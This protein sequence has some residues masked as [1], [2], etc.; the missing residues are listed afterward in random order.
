MGSQIE[1]LLRS[2]SP[3][4]VPTI[5]ASS[6]PVVTESCFMGCSAEFTNHTP[7]TPD[8]VQPG[9]LVVDARCTHVA[10]YSLE[11]AKAQAAHRSRLPVLHV[12]SRQWR[13]GRE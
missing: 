9:S 1:R 3:P 5:S 13:R 11:D 4:T 8:R 6:T 10:V 7:E 2:H 12:L